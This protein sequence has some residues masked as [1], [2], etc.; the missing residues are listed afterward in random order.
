MASFENPVP[1]RGFTSIQTDILVNAVRRL[2]QWT[3]MVVE[4]TDELLHSYG[5]VRSSDVETI[6]TKA[7]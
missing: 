7:A 4:R 5:F 3:D 1:E 6:R 2:D